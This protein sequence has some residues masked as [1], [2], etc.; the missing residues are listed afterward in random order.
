MWAWASKSTYYT[1]IYKSDSQYLR[2]TRVTWNFSTHKVWNPRKNNPINTPMKVTNHHP[3]STGPWTFFTLNLARAPP[4]TLHIASDTV[5]GKASNKRTTRQRNSSCHI[6]TGYLWASEHLVCSFFVHMW[7]HVMP[8]MRSNIA[9]SVVSSITNEFRVKACGCGLLILSSVEDFGSLGVGT[10]T[11]FSVSWFWDTT[12]VWGGCKACKPIPK[13]GLCENRVLLKRT[14]RP[15][16][17]LFLPC[18]FTLAQHL[19]LKS[20]LFIIDLRSFYIDRRTHHLLVYDGSLRIMNKLRPNHSG[21]S[22]VHSS[23][24]EKCVGHPKRTGP[25]TSQI[26]K[27]QLYLVGGFNPSEKY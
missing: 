23:Y 7:F 6:N 5:E 21:C 1:Y 17:F 25:G 26:N 16:R 13:M 11:G 18:C 22:T 20:Y 10:P 27:R 24:A 12:G 9:L 2:V 19:L 3:H 8:F 4:W 15:Y 14:L